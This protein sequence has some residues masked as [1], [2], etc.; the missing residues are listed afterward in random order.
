MPDW[1]NLV[2]PLRPPWHTDVFIIIYDFLCAEIL[3][4]LLA[5]APPCG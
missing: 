1:E 2:F 5:L 4:V 3:E